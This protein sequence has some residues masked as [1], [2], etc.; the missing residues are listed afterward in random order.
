MERTANQE[1]EG[2]LDISLPYFLKLNDAIKAIMRKVVLLEEINGTL[3]KKILYF[4]D[5]FLLLFLN[6]V[7]IVIIIVIYLFF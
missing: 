5:L 6:S 3:I 4:C 7:I 2:T 1:L